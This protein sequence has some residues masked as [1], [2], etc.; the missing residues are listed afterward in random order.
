M[1]VIRPTGGFGT[2]RAIVPGAAYKF[3]ATLNAAPLRADPRVSL[4]IIYRIYFAMPKIP[5]IASQHKLCVA[6]IS[7]TA[8]ATPP[9]ANWTARTLQVH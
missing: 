6:K 2:D 9:Q 8:H 3:V 5:E 1:T 4:Q 7:K